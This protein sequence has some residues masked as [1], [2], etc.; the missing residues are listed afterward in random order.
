MNL[1]NDFLDMGSANDIISEPAMPMACA[2]LHPDMGKA[3][4]YMDIMKIP[5]LK[6]LWR[7]VFGNECG[8]FFQGIRDIKG[9]NTCF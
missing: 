6:P 2:V 7:R 1:L 5:A 4:E 3:M 9:T 8:N